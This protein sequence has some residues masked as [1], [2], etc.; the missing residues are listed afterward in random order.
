MRYGLGNPT[1][2][3]QAFSEHFGLFGD[4]RLGFDG[5]NEAVLTPQIFSRNQVELTK[6]KLYK[7]EKPL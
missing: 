2:G 5:Q 7:T 6:N 3:N 1:V 4:R